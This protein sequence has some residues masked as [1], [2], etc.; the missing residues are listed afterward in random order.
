[1]LC[2]VLTADKLVIKTPKKRDS[3]TE[4]QYDLFEKRF[5][6]FIRN[7]MNDATPH[8]DSIG[9]YYTIKFDLAG[10]EV[11]RY[12]P[13]AAGERYAEFLTRDNHVSAFKSIP[14]G[15]DPSKADYYLSYSGKPYDYF[16]QHP[17]IKLNQDIL[18]V[19]SGVGIRYR[20][21]TG[22]Q[23][24]YYNY[25]VPGN[26]LSFIEPSDGSKKRLID[27]ET[28]KAIED[29]FEKFKVMT[30]H[31]FPTV[32]LD[33]ISAIGFTPENGPGAYVWITFYDEQHLVAYMNAV[34]RSRMAPPT[35]IPSLAK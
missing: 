31:S 16:D 27:F 18:S 19:C 1:M 10:N 5:K 32:T 17:E 8:S 14:V 21:E 34:D 11:E 24:V 15:S 25:I 7:T 22:D 35:Q 30:G 23:R 2:A 26:Y 33:D 6:A 28:E 3:M 4:I 20:E 29:S 13:S 9:T 12:Y